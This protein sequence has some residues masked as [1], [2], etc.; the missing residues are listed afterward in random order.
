MATLNVAGTQTFTGAAAADPRLGG[1]RGRSEP[2]GQNGRDSKA[3]FDPT[4][5]VPADGS[6]VGTAKTAGAEPG[7]NASII[8]AGQPGTYASSSQGGAGTGIA[9]TSGA[10]QGSVAIKQINPL[11]QNATDPLVIGQIAVPAAGSGSKQAD[12]FLTSTAGQGAATVSGAK[13]FN[14]PNSAYSTI[15]VENA[16]QLAAAGKSMNSGA[17]S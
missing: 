15:P 14:G 17:Q 6:R 13:G 2:Y 7:D 9:G 5:I 3:A 8:V 12:D 1:V 4:K 10:A 16:A 11:V